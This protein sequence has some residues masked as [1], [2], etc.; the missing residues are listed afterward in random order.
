MTPLSQYSCVHAG[1]PFPLAPWVPSSQSDGVGPHI[2]Y[3]AVMVLVFI[4]I[5]SL[6]RGPCFWDAPCCAGLR[7]LLL[8]HHALGLL[9]CWGTPGADTS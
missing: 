8:W 5:P 4:P 7:V 2:C 3:A 6:M 9:T 1:F